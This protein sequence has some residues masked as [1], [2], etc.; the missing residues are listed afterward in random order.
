MSCHEN[1][2]LKE[3]LYEEGLDR[4]MARGLN[5]EALE[6][7]AYHYAMKQFNLLTR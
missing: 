6:H 5:C 7:F 1:E 2:V 3:S 4:G